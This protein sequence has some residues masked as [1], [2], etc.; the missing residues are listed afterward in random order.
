MLMFTFFSFN[1]CNL[2]FR[3]NVKKCKHEYLHGYSTCT[4]ITNFKH[5]SSIW[6][7]FVIVVVKTSLV[8]FLQRSTFRCP[9]SYSSSTP[10]QFEPVVGS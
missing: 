5:L 6:N 7:R 10:L 9:P 4:T 3:I 8:G 1:Y 2:K